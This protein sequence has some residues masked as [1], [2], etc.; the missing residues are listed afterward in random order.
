MQGAATQDHAGCMQHGVA[1]CMQRRAAGS[2]QLAAGCMQHQHAAASRARRRAAFRNMTSLHNS[3]TVAI[4]PR[5]GVI[6]VQL[7]PQPLLALLH[8]AVMARS[9][10]TLSPGFLNQVRGV[11]VVECLEAGF[12]VC[13]RARV[14]W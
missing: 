8:K 9:T 3:I 2:M 5:S 12:S 1:L 13:C 14:T 7:P 4:R 10:T 6:K 11:V